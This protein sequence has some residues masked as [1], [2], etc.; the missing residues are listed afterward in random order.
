MTRK[1]N[2]IACGRGD[3]SH[4]CALAMARVCAQNLICIATS[5]SND[6]YI[7]DAVNAKPYG[8]PL[9]GL[10]SP[11]KYL[12][13]CAVFPSSSSSYISCVLVTLHSLVQSVTVVVI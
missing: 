3:G 8:T 12:Q 1:K 13:V 11:A 10:S 2:D 7:R 6:I 4:V 5:D 9:S